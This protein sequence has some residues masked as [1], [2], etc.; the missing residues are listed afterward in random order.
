M[1][2]PEQ[3]EIGLMERRPLDEL[4]VSMG[5]TSRIA[6]S[7]ILD[8]AEG[9]PGWAVALGDL[10]LRAHDASAISTGSGLYGEVTC[11][12]QRAGAD[13]ASIDL[14]GLVAALGVIE[15]DVSKAATFLGD[16]TTHI[17]TMLM[18]AA[19]G[20]LIDVRQKL[21]K[22]SSVPSETTATR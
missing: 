22:R 18:N 21:G 3:F 10:L 7:E 12:L 5:I 11:Y 6:R 1:R 17:A 2:G 13:D 19:V 20:G 16:T 14:L 8:Q 9:R 4:I 15:S